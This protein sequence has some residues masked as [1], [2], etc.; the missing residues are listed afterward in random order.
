MNHATTSAGVVTDAAWA[1]LQSKL[2]GELARPDDELYSLAQPWDR[3]AASQPAA[4]IMAA[5]ADDIVAVVTFACAEGLRVAVRATGHGAVPIGED[6]LLVHTQ[7]MTDLSVDVAGRWARAGA[8]VLWQQVLD[9]A[10]PAGLA[11]LC[12]SAPGVGVVGFLTGGGLGPFARTYGISSDYVRAFDVVTGDGQL[13]RATPTQN[14]DLFWGLRGGKATLGIVTA[15]EFDLPELAAFYGG[16]VWFAAEDTARVL[17]A[18]RQMAS[19][20]PEPGTTSA[21]IM[22]LPPL[23]Q[24]PPAIAGRQTLSIRFA[25]TADAE[26]GRRYLDE[27]RTVAAPLIDDVSVRPYADMACI[28]ADPVDPMPVN[29]CSALLGELSEDAITALIQAV[30]ERGPHTIVELRAL[31]GAIARPP[32]HRSAVCHREAAYQLFLSGSPAAAAATV[33]AHTEQVLSA[34]APW[35]RP[36]LLPNFAAS[37]DPALIAHCYDADTRHWLHALA[38]QYDPEHVLHTGQVVRSIPT[39]ATATGK[40]L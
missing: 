6:V 28:H 12:G 33:S 16:A 39:T 3:S 36:G 25:W 15:V 22:N 40:K 29:S 34:L 30:G 32:R 5:D 4:V 20:L 26:L 14:E 24:L 1:T 21:A 9:A 13:R 37:D 35:T 18:W 17:T 7:R 2:S 23:P 8:G 27:V 10:C 11:P 38:E 19:H 31:G